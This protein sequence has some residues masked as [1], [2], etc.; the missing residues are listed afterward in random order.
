MRKLNDSEILYRVEAGGYILYVI[1]DKLLWGLYRCFSSDERVGDYVYEYTEDA[2]S[3]AIRIYDANS[4][5]LN[6]ASV[7]DF[8][9]FVD[10]IP[11]KSIIDSQ[12]NIFMPIIQKFMVDALTGSLKIEEEPQ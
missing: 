11:D 10:N 3:E 5:V 4:F 9:A 8:G 1:Y 6:I 7:L 2:F 12:L